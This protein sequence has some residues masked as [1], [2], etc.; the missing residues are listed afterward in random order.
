MKPAIIYPVQNIHIFAIQ[1]YLLNITFDERF[2]KE[3]VQGCLPETVPC[4]HQCPQ[5]KQ[6][7]RNN[8]NNSFV[9]CGDKCIPEHTGENL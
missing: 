2:H 5:M 6:Q 3:N 4:H 1:R 7:N 9:P 8:H